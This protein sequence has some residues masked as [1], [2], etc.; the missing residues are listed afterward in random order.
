LATFAG[1]N[2]AKMAQVTIFS[3]VGRCWN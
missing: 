3:R 1:E 2:Q